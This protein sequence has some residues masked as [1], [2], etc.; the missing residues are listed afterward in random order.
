MCVPIEARRR[1]KKKKIIAMRRDAWMTRVNDRKHEEDKCQLKGQRGVV[2]SF[3]FFTGWVNDAVMLQDH[4]IT[5]GLWDATQQSY[6][7]EKNKYVPDGPLVVVSSSWFRIPPP[8]LS[9]LCS[10]SQPLTVKFISFF[11]SSPYSN[12]Y[13]MAKSWQTKTKVYVFQ[14]HINGDI[15][16]LLHLRQVRRNQI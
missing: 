15:V 5:H 7:R 11:Y 9:C 14:K 13:V 3:C 8:F 10:F 4:C 6:A 2:I 16:L 12:T 1:Q